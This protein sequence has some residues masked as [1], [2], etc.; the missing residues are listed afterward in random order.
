M[1]DY[2]LHLW[3]WLL[4]CFAIGAA[5]GSLTHRAPYG[6]VSRWLVWALLAFIV[7]LCAAA[8]GALRGAAGAALECAL[9]AFAVFL[10]GA[11]SA[12]LAAWRSWRWHEG[13][14]LGLVPVA[15]VWLGAIWFGA[16]GYEHDL[17][18]RAA[19][20]ATEAGADGQGVTASGRDLHPNPAIARDAGLMEKLAALPGVRK[21]ITPPEQIVRTDDAQLANRSRTETAPADAAKPRR[22]AE[23]RDLLAA[24]GD[25]PLTLTDCEAALD[26]TVALDPIT[27]REKSALIR[28][29]VM[30]A[31]DKAAALIRRC[32]D[33][34]IEVIGRADKI[35]R[36][37]DNSDLSLRRAAAAAHYLRREGVAGHR[38]IVVGYGAVRDGGADREQDRSVHFAVKPTM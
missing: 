7:G 11:A 30:Q 2:L 21:L 27:F 8:L 28:R 29:D 18:R 37:E 14:A 19:A 10:V 1:A 26:A 23:P 13:W 4:A 6:R 31:L 22:P 35:G 32:P 17:Q 9:A 33:V 20:L 38:L 5:A 16:A 25:G 15:L 36:E 34:A 24:L 12:A 3:P